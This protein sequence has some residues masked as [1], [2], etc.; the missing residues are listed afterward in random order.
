MPTTK[1]NKF[2]HLV[3]SLKA[4]SPSELK[5]LVKRFLIYM[6]TILGLRKTYRTRLKKMIAAINR[7]DF[8]ENKKVI[9]VDLDRVDLVDCYFS[10]NLFVFASK[11]EYSPLVLFEAC[12]AGLPFLTVPVGNAI[13][14]VDWTGGGEICDANVNDE[15]Y[16]VVDPAR[17]ALRIEEI[18]CDNTKLKKLSSS[19]RSAWEKAYNWDTIVDSYE[20]IFLSILNSKKG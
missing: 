6:L 16:T 1:R 14:I 10:S 15:G 9:Q 17:L 20:N 12:A 4:H 7:G 19:G 18:L 2:F 13:E 3:R 11:I 8:G 5:L